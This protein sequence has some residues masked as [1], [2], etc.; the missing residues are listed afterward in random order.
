MIV[1]NVP[2]RSHQEEKKEDSSDVGDRPNPNRKK[3][4]L[5]RPTPRRASPE[6]KPEDF[7]MA[8]CHA[9]LTSLSKSL[10]RDL[11][12]QKSISSISSHNLPSLS[13]TL[14]RNLSKGSR[15]LRGQSQA[16]RV[17]P[18]ETFPTLNGMKETASLHI[19]GV[20][21]AKRVTPTGSFT[22]LSPQRSDRPR[23]TCQPNHVAWVP[24][25]APRLFS[26]VGPVFSS[27]SA[28]RQGLVTNKEADRSMRQCVLTSLFSDRS[29]SRIVSKEKC[30]F[31]CDKEKE[32]ISTD[33]APQQQLGMSRVLSAPRFHEEQPSCKVPRDERPNQLVETSPDSFYRTIIG[34]LGYHSSS[35]PS[36]Q[37]K[38][39]F[40]EYTQDQIAAYDHAVTGAVRTDD[41]DALRALFQNGK[42][43]QCSNKFGESI[44]HMACRKGSLPVIRFLLEEADVSLRVCDDLGRTPLH[45]ACWASRPSF[46]AIQMLVRKEPDLLL[47]AD[48]RGHT[49]LSYAK[50]EMWGAW[51]QFLNSASSLL[52]PKCLI[53][54]KEED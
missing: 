39:Y 12:V 9:V 34:Q 32:S 25:Q 18:N 14:K 50:R 6:T 1:K 49:P 43:M 40:L 27:A 36:L 5:W 47:L 4:E 42:T 2:P 30:A 29:S 28:P 10:K 51:C 37:L 11:S 38:D 44:V 33:E 41:V 31:S 15:E 24:G 20:N 21:G 53:N 19:G 22:A 52:A 23:P 3:Y 45:D 7:G 54:T 46:E 35:V 13:K 48:K 8:A 26:G 17:L 16:A